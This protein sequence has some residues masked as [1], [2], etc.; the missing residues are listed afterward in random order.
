MASFLSPLCIF[1]F[2]SQ[3]SNHHHHSHHPL[4]TVSFVDTVVKL[5]ACYDDEFNNFDEWI[6]VAS[7]RWRCDFGAK[8]S[9]TNSHRRAENVDTNKETL[10]GLIFHF[11]IKAD[12][13]QIV[14]KE[15]LTGP[16][17]T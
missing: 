5:T 15:V 11:K 12:S 13:V 3:F 10:N 17:K 14:K 7:D 1:T 8:A 4:S 9:S 6:S 16:A 2:W